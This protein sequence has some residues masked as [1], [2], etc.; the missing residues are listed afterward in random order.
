MMPRPLLALRVTSQPEQISGA[1]QR[2]DP[3]PICEQKP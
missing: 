2:V 3:H 1:N